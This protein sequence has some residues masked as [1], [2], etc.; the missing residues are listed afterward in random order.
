MDIR[1]WQ[2]VNYTDCNYNELLLQ[3]LVPF[4]FGSLCAL[5]REKRK[6][7]EKNKY[8]LEGN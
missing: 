3:S 5:Q 1:Q 8:H 7:K 6:G 4:L 2:R